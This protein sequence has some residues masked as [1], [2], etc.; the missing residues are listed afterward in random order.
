M[1]EFKKGKKQKQVN[2][3]LM[4]ILRDDNVGIFRKSG[5]FSKPE[6]NIL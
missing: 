3:F 4:I 1:T 5:Y 6:N 2:Y